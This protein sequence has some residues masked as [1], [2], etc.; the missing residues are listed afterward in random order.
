MSLAGQEIDKN[1]DQGYVR[2]TELRTLIVDVS[3]RYSKSC[4]QPHFRLPF[5]FRWR[6]LACVSHY[7][8]MGLGTTLRSY[9]IHP[10]SAP[11]P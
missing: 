7:V 5:L 9:L 6:S 3:L 2:V 10:A 4:S 8:R 1:L 11:A